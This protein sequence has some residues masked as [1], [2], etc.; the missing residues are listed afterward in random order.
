MGAIAFKI[1]KFIDLT[2]QI[3][4]KKIGSLQKQAADLKMYYRR[5]LL[6]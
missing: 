1:K 4:I 5:L 2:F 3:R 6:N